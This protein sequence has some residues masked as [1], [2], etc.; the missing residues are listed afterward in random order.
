MLIECGGYGWVNLYQVSSIERREGG[1]LVVHMMGGAGDIA[2]LPDEAEG[3]EVALRMALAGKRIQPRE[4][5][6]RSG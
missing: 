3:V 4:K 6:L 2:L 5:E 1:A